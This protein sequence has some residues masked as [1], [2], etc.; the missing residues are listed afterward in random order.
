MLSLRLRQ[1]INHV[2]NQLTRSGKSFATSHAQRSIHWSKDPITCHHGTKEILE[3]F[4]IAIRY[5]VI[6]RW[7]RTAELA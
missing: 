1:I 5:D 3:L 7:A 2:F 6:S 4:V